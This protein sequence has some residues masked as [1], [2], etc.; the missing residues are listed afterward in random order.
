MAR[1]AAVVIRLEAVTVALHLGVA[2]VVLRQAAS[3]VL[4]RVRPA[5]LRV[6]V[7]AFLRVSRLRAASVVLRAFRLRVA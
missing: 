2:S 5:H 4:R 6:A 1:P 7:M 3:V